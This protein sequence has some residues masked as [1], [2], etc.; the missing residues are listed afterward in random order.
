MALQEI[1]DRIIADARSEAEQIMT[2]AQ[3]GAERISAEA[4][5]RIE[6][7]DRE[8]QTELDAKVRGITAGYAASARL[9][10]NKIMLAAKR[11]VLDGVFARV[12]EKLLSLEKDEYIALCERL[13]EAYA[14]EGDVLIF[15]DNF[16]Y[17]KE[18]A[19]LKRVQELKIRTSFSET[20]TDGM[21]LRGKSSDKDL[22][23]TSLVGQYRD[24][25][26][27]ETASEIF[28]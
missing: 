23:F 16:P 25:H 21:L 5:A 19:S 6:Q 14:E 13:I 27:A 20:C 15:A 8:A 9:E 4:A 18:V 12:L 7:A 2:T 28:R 22:S 24:G 1:C 3:S 10:G 11:K 26:E 17:K